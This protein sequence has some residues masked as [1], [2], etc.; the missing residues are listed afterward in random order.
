MMGGFTIV[1]NQVNALS[2]SYL[3]MSRPED[4]GEVPVRSAPGIS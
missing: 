1:K 4:R 2:L 3:H